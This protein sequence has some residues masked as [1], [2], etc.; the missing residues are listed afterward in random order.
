MGGLQPHAILSD[1][2]RQFES[3]C[4]QALRQPPPPRLVRL[5]VAQK[6]VVW[7]ITWHN[8]VL[9]LRGFLPEMPPVSNGYFNTFDRRVGGSDFTREL[10]A[11]AIT[12]SNTRCRRMTRGA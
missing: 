10:H 6:N 5:D 3:R 12:S 8:P 4:E 11:R 7:K 2:A 1:L 9:T